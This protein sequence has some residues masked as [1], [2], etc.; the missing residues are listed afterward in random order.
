MPR[1]DDA[2]AEAIQNGGV[3]EVQATAEK[4]PLAWEEVVALK[5]LADKGIAKLAA[6]QL[7]AAKH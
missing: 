2:H 7:E 6:L 5:H 3:I 1:R 4:R